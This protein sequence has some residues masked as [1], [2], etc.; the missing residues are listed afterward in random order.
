MAT[1]FGDL[2]RVCTD[3]VTDSTPL[4][5]YQ[6]ALAAGFV[7]D[8]AQGAAVVALD[9]CARSVNKGLPS[10]RGIYLWG[11]VGRG[12]T[13][14]MDVFFTSLDVPARRQHH[15]H[16]MRWVHQR[17]FAL[18]GVSDPLAV[19]AEELANAVR[20]LCLDEF[21]V[22]DIGD[23][24]I[25]GGL[26]QGL[27]KRKVL[28]VMTSNQPPSDLYANGHHRERLI[29]AIEAIERDMRVISVNGERDHRLTPG[30]ACSRYFVEAPEGTSL[31]NAFA[32]LQ[33]GPAS[34]EPLVIGSCALPVI[35]RSASA[36]WFDYDAL[37][38]QPLAAADYIGLCDRYR[39]ILLARVPQMTGSSVAPGPA[40]GTE[41]ILDNALMGD[42]P[43]PPLSRKDNGARRFIALVDEC[44]DRRVALWVQSEVGID[45]L[46]PKQGYLGFAFRR[47][48]SRLKE[49]QLARFEAG[50]KPVNQQQSP[51]G[52]TG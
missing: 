50:I 44:Y 31:A 9:H 37:C 21:Y 27:L 38:E 35:A 47:T 32:S 22:S 36:V 6:N 7:E 52:E 26:I 29:P 8:P 16:F 4:S 15:H 3:P 19:L 2:K 40:M 1:I 30:P 24:M 51:A 13:W 5:V 33:D 12:K 39:H 43:L 42:R 34:S 17:L 25:L 41:D 14:L 48:V 46:Y 18:T 11:R 20:V 23:A 45:A 28:L 10:I 49:M